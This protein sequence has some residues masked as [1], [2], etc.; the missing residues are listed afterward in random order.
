MDLTRRQ[1]IDFGLG[2]ALGLS[3]G[4]L[5]RTGGN[6]QGSGESEIDPCMHFDFLLWRPEPS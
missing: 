3:L 4:G 1:L 5:W 2:G 6:T